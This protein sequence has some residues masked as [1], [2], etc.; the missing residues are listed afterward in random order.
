MRAPIHHKE[1][2]MTRISGGA[3][4]MLCAGLVLGGA[5]QTAQAVDHSFSSGFKFQERDGEALYQ[6][7]CQGCHMPQGQGAIG[8]GA[9]PALAGNPRLASKIYPAFMVINGKKAMPSFAGALD[10]DQVA[11]VANYVR[12]HFGNQYTDQVTPAEVKALRP[13]APPADSE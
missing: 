10:D 3:R 13:K 12:S 6:G 4:L 8:A 1:K 2:L 7:I 11:A 9:Y 5:G